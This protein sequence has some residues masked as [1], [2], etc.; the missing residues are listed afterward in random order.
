MSQQKPV[1]KSLNI[2]SNLRGKRFGL[3]YILFA[4]P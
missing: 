3:T 2:V 1:N 4:T